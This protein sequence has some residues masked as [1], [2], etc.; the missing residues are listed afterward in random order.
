[1]IPGLRDQLARPLQP[2]RRSSLV[3]GYVNVVGSDEAEETR[4]AGHVNDVEALRQAIWHIVH[5]ERYS[6]PGILENDEGIELEQFIGESFSYF[7]AKVYQVFS[8]AIL[9]DDRVR[10]VRLI[11]TSN[12]NPTEAHAEFEIDSVFGPFVMGFDVPLSERGV[13]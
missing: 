1:M 2:V 8:D 3:W 7:R 6:Y 11:S 5:T 12:P 13:T 10:A 9:R 4:L